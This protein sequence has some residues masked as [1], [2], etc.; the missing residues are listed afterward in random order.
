MRVIV[1]GAGIAGLTAARELA[2][3]G[4]EVVV[5]EASDRVGG[6]VWTARRLIGGRAPVP[7]P[8]GVD[9]YGGAAQPCGIAELLAG[10]RL[11][12]VRTDHGDRHID[13]SPR[14]K[15]RDVG[16]IGVEMV[17]RVQVGTRVTDQG[18]LRD[19][20][21]HSAAQPGTGGFARGDDMQLRPGEPRIGGHAGHDLVGQFD[22][23]DA[24]GSRADASATAGR[25]GISVHS[26]S[27][28]SG[29]WWS[30]SYRHSP[31]PSG[32]SCSRQSCPHSGQSPYHRD[33][34]T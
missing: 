14:R 31:H 25:R 15:L 33:R 1:V 28:A 29:C 34:R 20:E 22:D 5:L 18:Q 10:D 11:P 6:Q 13:E 21:G 26:V 24:E 30:I 16:A 9:E 7:G 17:G 3:A 4:H 8:T 23:H 19:L 32:I 27:G 2:A 12:P